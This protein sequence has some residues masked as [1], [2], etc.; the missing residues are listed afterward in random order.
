MKKIKES[1]NI[2]GRDLTIET[3]LLAKQ[4]S[5]A[6]LIKYGETSNQYENKI[7]I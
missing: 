1:K 6:V 4:A 7:Y 5:G 2:G 3:G